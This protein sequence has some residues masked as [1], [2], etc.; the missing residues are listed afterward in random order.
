MGSRVMKW[1]RKQ[2]NKLA[3]WWLNKQSPP[4]EYIVYINEQEEKLLKKHG[5]AGDIWQDTGIRSFFHKKVKRFFKRAKKAVKKAIGIILSPFQAIGK[6]LG[7]LFTPDIPS[8]DSADAYDSAQQGILVNKQSS[9]GSIP[10]I[11]GERKVGGYRV[12]ISN[13]GSGRNEYLYVALVMSEGEIDSVQKLYI[14]DEEIP[15]NGALT[16]GTERE[17]SS[18][19]FKDRL[20]VQA[21]MGKD[22]QSASSLLKGAPGWGNS[23]R[24]RGLAYIACRFEWKKATEQELK[25]QKNSNPYAGVPDIVAIV[26]GKKVA[27]SYSG[28]DTTSAVSTYNTDSKSYSSNPADCLLDYLR[29]PRYGKGLD[30]N[31]I[32]FASFNEARDLLA[33]TYNFASGVTLPLLDCNTLLK[34]DDSIFNNTK[35]LLQAC[36]GLLPY[37]EGKY[38]LVVETSVSSPGD[39]FEIND[40][41]IVGDLSVVGEGKDSKFNTAQVTFTNRDK[42]HETDTI[43]VINPTALAADNNEVLKKDFIAPGITDE[44]Q[45]ESFAEKVI[46]KSRKGKVVSFKGDPELAILQIGDV[47]KL[48]HGY[49]GDDSDPS[50]AGHWMFNYAHNNTT[51]SLFRVSDLKHDVD[52]LVQVILLE[53]DNDMW[54]ITQVQEKKRLNEGDVNLPG[55]PSDPPA[56]PP[57]GNVKVEYSIYKDSTGTYIV[58]KISNIDPT[59]THINFEF[60]S[61]GAENQYTW[62]YNNAYDPWRVYMNTNNARQVRYKLSFF[63]ETNVYPIVSTFQTINIPTT[64]PAQYSGTL[65]GG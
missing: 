1:I 43:Y 56:D 16:H 19:R 44:Y 54:D 61:T 38:K 23:H 25:D 36:R 52:G 27:T 35:I 49:Y 8:Y 41:N 63:K 18:G 53:H 11:Y 60:G 6:I 46:K 15:L 7:G 28:K 51:N 62:T 39:L 45:V 31:R 13:N 47:V 57:A 29:N 64:L 58:F 59:V 21:F 65:I 48:K 20:K 30:D 26:R 5:G 33:T 3:K 17:P 37:Q 9:A 40:D 2:F 10:V 34:T 4:G 55:G 32:N 24:L 12:F 22:D 50:I 42:N 14:N